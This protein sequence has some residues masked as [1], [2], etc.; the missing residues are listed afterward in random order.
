MYAARITLPQGAWI[1]SSVIQAPVDGL[2]GQSI[3]ALIGR[4]ILSFG[5]LIYLGHANQFTL[6]F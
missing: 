4:D 3:E 5:I 1:D 6:S 2:T